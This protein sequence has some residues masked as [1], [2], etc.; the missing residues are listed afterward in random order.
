MKKLSQL[1][2][3]YN[4]INL[5]KN[6]IY[7]KLLEYHQL[8]EDNHLK[9]KIKSFNKYIKSTILD[10]NLYFLKVGVDY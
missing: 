5:E 2:K 1:L 4:K 10:N 6:S 9:I 7:D 8:F 3:K